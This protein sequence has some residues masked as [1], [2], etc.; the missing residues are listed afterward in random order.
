M[1][2]FAVGA[3]SFAVV[4]AVVGYIATSAANSGQ[5]GDVTDI[6]IPTCKP[7]SMPTRTHAPTV[8]RSQV[9]PVGTMYQD[10]SSG[11]VYSIDTTTQYTEYRADGTC[12]TLPYYVINTNIYMKLTGSTMYTMRSGGMLTGVDLASNTTSVYN[13]VTSNPN[14]NKCDSAKSNRNTYTNVVDTFKQGDISQSTSD[15]TNYW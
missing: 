5:Y 12:T 4:D 1:I 3:I 6:I 9:I 15:I 8:Y 11:T 2:G 7:T 13:V 14:A 10:Q